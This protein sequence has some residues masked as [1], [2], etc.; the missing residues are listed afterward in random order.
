[1]QITK[2]REERKMNRKVRLWVQSCKTLPIR[3]INTS[4]L[5]P[6]IRLGRRHAVSEGLPGARGG[7]QEIIPA[8]LV[9]VDQR[10]K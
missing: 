4:E 5:P 8:L 2:S 9:T 6:P 10:D 3:F 1:M 7:E